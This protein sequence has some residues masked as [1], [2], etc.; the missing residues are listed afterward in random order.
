M[1]IKLTDNQPVNEKVI[2]QNPLLSLK[3]WEINDVR[4]QAMTPVEYHPWHYHKEVELL[5]ILDGSLAVQTKENDQTL[6]SGDVLIM[7][8]SQPHRTSKVR[9]EK[10]RYIVLQIDLQK[11]FDQS[12][13]PYFYCF[14]ELTHPLERIN[15]IFEENQQIKQE[16]HFLINEIH[17]ESQTKEKGYEIAI[18]YLIKRLLLLLVRNDTKNLLHYSEEQDLTRLKPVLDYIDSHLEERILVEDVCVLLNFSYHHFIKYFKKVMGMSFVDY[19]NLKRIKKA[20]LLLLTTDKS[21]L[22][23]SYE[24]GI[25]NMAQFYK[26][27]KRENQCSPKAFKNK[28]LKS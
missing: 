20:E 10:L 5:A 12:I 26:L 7:G 23:I 11:H 15:Y 3:V 16:V 2:Y 28:M 8:A 6:S 1:G 14:S 27:F 13:L 18:N 17:R 21:I 9:K 4:E 22:E 25:T 19:I 24:A